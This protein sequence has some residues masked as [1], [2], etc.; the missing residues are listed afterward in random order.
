MLGLFCWSFSS[1]F[2]FTLF[3]AC[4]GTPGQ[5]KLV[6]DMSASKFGSLARVLSLPSLARDFKFLLTPSNLQELFNQPEDFVSRR[7][8]DFTRILA[9]NEAHDFE[10][11]EWMVMGDD[12]P[13]LPPLR[14][15][16]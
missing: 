14:R 12:F 8:R 13:I 6:D 10:H 1:F 15:D 4:V 9:T 7:C 5:G 11:T 2:S 3:S 16:L